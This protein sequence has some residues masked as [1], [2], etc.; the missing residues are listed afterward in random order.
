MV[1]AATRMLAIGGTVV[2]DGPLRNVNLYSEA[3][4]NTSSEERTTLHMELNCIDIDTPV[5][6][7]R[8]HKTHDKGL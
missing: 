8:G 5:S 6:Q 3:A 7:S 4:A 2:Q 1:Y